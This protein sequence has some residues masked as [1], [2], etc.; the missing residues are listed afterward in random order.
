MI[1]RLLD[2]ME[3]IANPK[4]ETPVANI[5]SY[6][7]IAGTAPP[8]VPAGGSG[9]YCSTGSAG[10]SAGIAY[11]QHAQVNKV[12]G[13]GLPMFPSGQVV[14]ISFRDAYGV[15]FSLAVDST[16]VTL[17]NHID[18]IHGMASAQFTPVT[19]FKMNDADFSIDELEKA[20]KVMEELGYERA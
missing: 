11:H 17:M 9:T 8:T 12:N 13:M 5:N 10:I 4:K 19:K 1:S 20:E 7:G 6:Y 15:M 14:T 3:K 18:G 16:V 2:Y